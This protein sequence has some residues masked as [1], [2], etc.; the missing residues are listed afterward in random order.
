MLKR[1]PLLL[2]FVACSQA[3]APAPTP[4]QETQPAPPPT[5]QYVLSGELRT[6]NE[7]AEPMATEMEISITLSN[8]QHSVT[9]NY[10]RISLMGRTYNFYVTWQNEWGPPTEWHDFTTRR[11][12]HLPICGKTCV[13]GHSCEGGNLAMNEP[14]TGVYQERKVDLRCS[15]AQ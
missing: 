13:N 5:T 9:S 10:S 11:F 7:C 3:P 14:V 4:K 12:D 1:L 6:F 15:C 2:L 8:A